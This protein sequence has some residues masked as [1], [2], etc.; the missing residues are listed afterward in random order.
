MYILL[1]IEFWRKKYS[2]RFSVKLIIKIIVESYIVIKAVIS[3]N[4]ISD[5]CAIHQTQWISA[6]QNQYLLSVR[7]FTTINH[8]TK[9]IK[10]IVYCVIGLFESMFSS[11]RIMFK[12]CHFTSSVNSIV[13]KT[14]ISLCD[15][16][17]DMTSCVWYEVRWEGWW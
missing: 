15:W 7:S 6:V 9:S 8:K 4:T 17:R 3:T 5:N 14:H 16:G 1:K 12:F 10:L 13:G 11:K 2:C